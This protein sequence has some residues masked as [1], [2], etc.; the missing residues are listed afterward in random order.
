[1]RSNLRNQTKGVDGFEYVD[2]ED[3]GAVEY[4]Q[5]DRL[6]DILRRFSITGRASFDSVD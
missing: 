2:I 6:S 5:V 1:M 3:I 4:G